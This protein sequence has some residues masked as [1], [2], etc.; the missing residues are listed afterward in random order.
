MYPQKTPAER[1][2]QWLRDR[3]ILERDFRGADILPSLYE[4]VDTDHMYT[5]YLV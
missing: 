3:A 2:H 1:E 4:T 5:F